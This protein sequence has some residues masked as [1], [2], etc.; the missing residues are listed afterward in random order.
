MS[1]WY[2][3]SGDTAVGPLTLQDMKV[4]ARRGQIHEQ[5]WVTCEGGPYQRAGTVK[6]FSGLL[7]SGA[8]DAG[9]PPI[10]PWPVTKTATT[11]IAKSGGGAPSLIQNPLVLAGAVLVVVIV[12][13]WSLSGGEPPKPL[14]IPTLDGKIPDL[15]G[16]T[17]KAPP[18]GDGSY[19]VLLKTKA[20]ISIPVP[21]EAWV[22][23][24]MPVPSGFK[25][26]TW[27]PTGMGKWSAAWEISDNDKT[28]SVVRRL[29]FSDPEGPL[30]PD[31]HTAIFTS[32]RACGMPDYVAV[33]RENR[34]SGKS[35]PDFS[36]QLCFYWQKYFGGDKFPSTEVSFFTAM[37]KDGQLMDQWT[38]GTFQLDKASL[39]KAIL[40]KSEDLT[41]IGLLGGDIRISH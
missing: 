13:F 31:A 6:D 30:F 18:I 15:T 26:N 27:I 34:K 37:F 40:D 14:I 16:P 32:L 39:E 20:G 38:F 23:A 3:H 36:L 21:D 24:G 4:A 29:G 28:T 9:L 33:I 22:S 5:S 11:R 17:I 19:R 25:L 12:A 8:A 41:S 10:P 35:S 1:A 7:G 2:Y